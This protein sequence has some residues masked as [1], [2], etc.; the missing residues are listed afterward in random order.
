MFLPLTPQVLIL[1]VAM[2]LSAIGGWKVTAMHYQ[3]EIAGMRLDKAK[4]AAE[5]EKLN[6]SLSV[7]GLELSGAISERNANRHEKIRVIEI[8]V[9]RDVIKYRNRPVVLPVDGTCYLDAEWVRLANAAASGG[10]SEAPTG[11]GSADQGA[12]YADA[13]ETVTD[14]Y[15]TCNKLR[16][17]VI[18]WQEFYEGVRRLYEH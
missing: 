18:G 1:A 4:A 7:A 2:A 11:A 13:I 3:A 17:T 8:E 9:L 10:V 15:S 16:A 5:A 12:T 14:N 6:H